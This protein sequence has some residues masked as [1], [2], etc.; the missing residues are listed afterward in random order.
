MFEAF[1]LRRA[2]VDERSEALRTSVGALR[3]DER[4]AFYEACEPRIK[5]PDTYAALNW[6][7]LAG[8]HHMY[9]GKWVRGSCNLVV[10]L[11]GLSLLLT[12]S[13]TGLVVMLAVVLIELPALFRAELIVREH[14]V[15][16]G[17]RTLRTLRSP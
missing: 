2:R 14:N 16:L 12:G 10:M 17:E 4:R 3:D 5:D 8:I 11:I 7:F 15:R 9:L 1:T 13:G 6:F